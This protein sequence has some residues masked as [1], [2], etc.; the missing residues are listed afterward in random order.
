MRLTILVS[1]F[2]A[3]AVPALLPAQTIL[4]VSQTGGGQYRDV[5][6][7]VDAANPGDIILV[8]P[9][10][11][12]GF[13]VSKDLRVL[14]DPGAQFGGLLPATIG[15]QS[16]PAGQTALLRGIRVVRGEMF[17]GGCDGP[18]HIEDSGDT[19]VSIYNS[20]QV[21]VHRSRIRVRLHIQ[22]SRVLVT[23]CEIVG[24]TG[25]WPVPLLDCVAS[26]VTFANGTI[27]ANPPTLLIPAAAVVVNHGSVVTIAG[28]ARTEVDNRAGVQA[29]AI[30]VMDGTL[31]LDPAVTLLPVFGQPPVAVRPSGTMVTRPV[32]WLGTDLTGRQLTVGGFAPAGSTLVLVLGL[33]QAPPI[34]LPFGTLWVGAAHVPVDAGVVPPSGVRTSTVGLPTLQLGLHGVLQSVVLSS[35]ITL[36]EP[37]VLTL[38][39]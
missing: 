13:T 22:N 1:C 12:G 31:V 20:R 21:S 9:G 5:Q 8:R 23:Q 10:W 33:V 24:N 6:P 39:R 18:V 17:V 14:A 2:I 38:D 34:A 19:T 37:V 15:C 25:S 36:S 26:Q 28:D 29:P 35:V 4:I 7:A 11:Y 27:V 16:L 3:G 30:D 32:P